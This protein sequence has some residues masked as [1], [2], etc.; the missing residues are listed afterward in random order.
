MRKPLLPPGPKGLPI[1]GSLI[2]FFRDMLG[3]MINAKNEYGDIVHF[4]ILGRKVFL[5]NHPELI[6][7]VL[8]K[9]DRNFTKSRALERSKLILGNGLITSE[10]EY[11]LR[12]RRLAQ[13][14]FHHQRISSYGKIMADY[15][16]HLSDRWQEGDTVEMH[17][18]MMTLTLA[19][20][21]KTLYDTDVESETDEIGN[22][23]TVIIDMFPRMLFPFSEILDKIPLPETIRFE[24]ARER[25]NKTVYGMIEQRRSSGEDRGDLLSMFL[26]AQDDEGDGGRMSD[27]Q[28][29]DEIMTIF[30]AGHET[31]A[32]ALTWTWYLLSQNPDVER[33]LHEELDMVLGDRSPSVEDLEHLNYT[34]MVLTESMR[35]YPPVWSMARSAI[36]D[37]KVRNYD[38]PARSSIFFCQYIIH[39]DPRFYPEPLSFDPERWIP[40]QKRPTHQYTYFPFGG[41][42]RR[43]IGEQFAWME[44]TLV[45]AAIA[46]NWKFRLVPGHKVDIKPM[47]TLRPKY[48]M[49]MI[50]RKR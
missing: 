35:M 2:A 47:I 8:V 14:A 3:F 21:G 24:K 15:A 37:Y 22:A 28:V 45:I 40:D 6:K 12:Q 9:H 49:N 39:R 50:V 25:L 34:R 29:R 4:K 43:C 11:H 44:G 41:G 27:L 32:N 1:F 26:I 16:S 48:G 46:R 10:G 31:V 30:L 5:L 13:P 19:I 38:V 36:N 17:R 7:D 42:P 20:V 18:E 33:K 23:V